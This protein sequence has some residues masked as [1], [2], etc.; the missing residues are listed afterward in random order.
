MD[1]NHHVVAILLLLP[2]ATLALL[3][4]GECSV[5]DMTCQID[6]ENVIGIIND[7]VSAQECKDECQDDSNDC[8]VYSYY[9]SAG[10]P[11]AGVQFNRHLGY[12][13][14]F[15]VWIRDKFRDISLLGN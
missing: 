4:N 3:P 13:V 6:N 14:E 5:P 7:A 11:F 15:R 10:F 9:G 1:V 2:S 12:K 8:M